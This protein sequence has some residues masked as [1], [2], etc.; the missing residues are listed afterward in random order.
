MGARR[1]ILA[2]FLGLALAVGAGAP[3]FSQGA[4]TEALGTPVGA[5]IVYP[6]LTLGTEYNDNI[7]ATDGDEEDDIIFRI[8][9]QVLVASDWDNHSLQF[10]G[11]GNFA[12]YVDN[13]SE[14]TNG[15]RFLSDGRVDILRDTFATL[16][17][18][19]TQTFEERGSADDVNGE[20]PTKELTYG[21]G[22]GFFHTFNRVW[23]ELNG[24]VVKRDFSDVDAA[25]GGQINQDDR[26]R[27]EY[28]SS[29]RVGYDFNPDIGAFLQTTFARTSYNDSSDD[30]GDSRDSIDYSLSGGLRLDVTDLIFGDVFAGVTRSEFDDSAFDTETTWNIGGNL[31]WLVTELTTANF[32]AARTWEETTVEGSSTALTTTAGVNVNHSLTDDVSLDGFFNYTREEFE[33]TNRV[34][35]TYSLGP[36]VNYLMNRFLHWRLNYTYTQRESDA[37]GEDYIEN[38]ILLTARLQY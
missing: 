9:P 37:V 25:G 11:E 16:N 14:D 8:R 34:D 6:S 2:I 1:W 33:G 22:A 19:V 38:L 7:F 23:L 21:G 12:R 24:S 35:D 20:E 29:Q 36:G 30:F 31:T 27:I 26:D 5:F 17:A 28:S 15:F 3:A 13:T 4:G 10:L 18:G 32:S